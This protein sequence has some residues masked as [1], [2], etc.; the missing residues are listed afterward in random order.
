MKMGTCEKCGT[1]WSE[2]FQYKDHWLC[3]SNCC[4]QEEM[5]KDSGKIDRDIEKLEEYRQLCQGTKGI[6]PSTY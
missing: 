4:Y 6:T 2:L 5:D 1:K 3:K